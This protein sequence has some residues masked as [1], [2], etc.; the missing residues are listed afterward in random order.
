[1][2]AFVG[3]N[4]AGKS[5]ILSALRLFASGSA[6]RVTD[7]T[8]SVR[9]QPLDPNRVVVR[10]S[11]TLTSE[12]K[13][14]AAQLPIE[15]KELRYVVHQ[16]HADGRRTYSFE[17]PPRVSTSPRLGLAK[18][19][20][21]IERRLALVLDQ[22]EEDEVEDFD[23]DE[24]DAVS[25]FLKGT[26]SKPGSEVWDSVNAAIT[27]HAA[28][29][30][31][32]DTKVAAFSLFY[33]WGRPRAEVSRL[34]YERLG[35]QGPVFAQFG[36]EHRVIRS[37]YNLSDS[38]TEQSLG[39][40]NLLRLAGITLDRIRSSAG[41]SGY[42]RTLVDDANRRLEQFF[43]QKWKQEQIT[44]G[45][46]V[47]GEVLRVHVRDLV[48]GSAGWMDITERSDGLRTF[49][50]LAA[51]LESGGFARPPI[52]LID[53]A[54]HHLHQNAQGDLVRM[55]QELT[56]VEQVL[57]TT[58]S[59][60]CLPSDIG[61]GVRFVEPIDNGHSRIR[62][63]FWTIDRQEHVG[64]NPLLIVMGAGAAAFSSLRRAL[65]AEGESDMLLLPTLIKLATGNA[66]LAYQVAPGIATANTSE[67]ASLDL[68]ASRVAYMV[69]G[70]GG[71]A[72]WKSQLLN[73]GVPRSRIRSLPDG[74]GLEDLL[75]RAFY[76]DSVAR[77]GNLDRASLDKAATDVPIKTALEQLKVRGLPGPVAVAEFLLGMHESHEQ[78]IVLKTSSRRVLRDL[79]AWALKSLRADARP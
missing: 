75:D 14:L 62:H 47:D 27:E 28:G 2:V 40:A 5:S 56:A 61:N 12:E 22:L 39:L 13:A 51:F 52:L 43:T 17:P 55:L 71:G 44:V 79:D 37:E 38:D 70:D 58:H 60:A 73:S 54:E 68:V 26:G 65:I 48:V 33:E 78:L 66:D 31:K 7:A 77:L 9:G 30:P 59:P 8:R 46:D 16:K 72:R 76:L 64:F 15:D 1:M 57:Y 23:Q 11:F 10:L 67:M 41:D 6:I 32:L 35:M 63:D 25:A 18:A 50:G 21:A 20:P 42:Q 74:V 49:V 4:E 69:D 45:I 34:V 29:D 19:W 53:E 24:L 36:D 3:P